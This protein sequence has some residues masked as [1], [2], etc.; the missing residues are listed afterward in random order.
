MSQQELK[1]HAWDHAICDAFSWR[2]L[3][4]RQFDMRNLNLS[5][6]GSSNQKQFRIATE[7]FQSAGYQ[8]LR[9]QFDHIIVLWGIT[10]TAR[11]ELWS[12]EHNDYHNFF[13][14]D[15]DVFARW[16]TK[17]CYDHDA[18]VFQLR[19]LML[20]WNLFFKSQNIKNFWFDS[21]NTH[22]YDFDYSSN[23]HKKTYEVDPTKSIER[24]HYHALAGPDWPSYRQFCAG[25][26]EN[27][28]AHIQAEVRSFFPNPPPN[29]DNLLP[30]TINWDESDRTLEPIPN[31]LYNQRWP[32]DLM[33]WLM[34]KTNIVTNQ[35]GQEYH[36]SHWHLDRQG[37]EKLVAFDLLNPHSFHPTKKGHRML[38]DYFADTL[39][40]ELA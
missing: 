23:R 36:I 18:E 11:N 17:H 2:A 31:L 30:T 29:Y 13:L 35:Q 26:L 20:F 16:I 28:P 32:R 7:F 15:S 1:E 40:V 39:H 4:C 12:V 22:N 33:S 27:F 9:Q 38:V 21:F 14:S 25:E 3:L 6:G 24:Q 19:K 34:D 37:M 5:A 8:K 10:S